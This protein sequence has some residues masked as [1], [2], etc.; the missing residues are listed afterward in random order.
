[1]LFV[2][3]IAHTKTPMGP[4]N[5]GAICD[6]LNCLVTKMAHAPTS[7]FSVYMRAVGNF[8]IFSL[9][10]SIA[11]ITH[12]FSI[13]GLVNVWALSYYFFKV[14]MLFVTIIAHVIFEVGLI[15]VGAVGDL[16]L[17]QLFL[18]FGKP[19]LL[20]WMICIIFSLKCIIVCSLNYICLLAQQ[21]VTD[22]FFE[23]L[24]H[25]F[26]RHRF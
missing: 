20:F 13:E 4:L 1:M 17:W 24:S 22:K 14:Q 19:T 8:Q 16:K 7:I 26:L 5:M 25:L 3:K 9:V 2:T 6:Y 23:L 21:R 15:N 18:T 12:T 10:W 11:A